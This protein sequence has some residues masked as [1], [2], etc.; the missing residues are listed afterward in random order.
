NPELGGYLL[1]PLLE[2]QD[3]N[4]YTQT[5]AAMNIGTAYPN[6]T[7][8]GI[9]NAHDY[10]VEASE[11]ANMLIM[12]LAYS[13][14][15]G[16]G[17]F[18]ANHYTLLRKWADFLVTNALNPINQ[19]SADFG[20]T[21]GLSNNNQTNTALKGI[22][23]IA[24]MAK[25][26]EIA[27]V[28]DDQAHF[29]ETATSYIE[30][31]T[32]DAIAADRTHVDFFYN[33][34]N[35]NGLMYNLYADKLLNL[36]LVPDEVYQVLTSFYY[37]IANQA[38]YGL[39]LSNQNSSVAT[40]S[41]IMFAASALTN[42]TTRDLMVGQLHGYVSANLNSTPF[43]AVYNP[44]SGQAINGQGAGI[45]SPTI[46][47]L[48][49]LLALNV[50]TKPISLPNTGSTIPGTSSNSSSS[51]RHKSN[52]AAIGGGIGGGLVVLIAFGLS[53]FFCARR[54]REALPR[55]RK[56]DTNKSTMSRYGEGRPSV[57]S[58]PDMVLEPFLLGTGV[59]TNGHFA[60]APY[61]SKSKAA[62]VI[63]HSVLPSG[64]GPTGLVASSSTD[65]TSSSHQRDETSE[66]TM[67]SSSEDTGKRGRGN[68]SPGDGIDL[69]Q[70]VTALQPL[71]NERLR[72]EVE[73]LRR[74]VERL[75]RERT[76]GSLDAPP[77]YSEPA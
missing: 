52:A 67:T 6:A 53:V 39:P 17:T 49:S 65:R 55:K 59:T 44:I 23:G 4:A 54:R 50:T 5:Y 18:L 63:M 20:I 3:S 35:S 30:Q 72:S 25:I 33:T 66:S 1:A 62:Q 21:S 60:S 45:N 9:D 61:P 8:D 64:A 26:S 22:I 58:A 24:T 56:R 15:S 70:V 76:S 47:S 12:T 31:W 69:Q 77:L 71:L 7:A 75:Q 32:S 27:G 34:P 41:S 46:G 73:N 57:P 42:T 43:T 10:Q 36:D 29:N 51:L 74:D 40:L 14:A 11:T 68:H 2:Y 48:F 16:N 37:N 38:N 19:D 13:Q 28:G